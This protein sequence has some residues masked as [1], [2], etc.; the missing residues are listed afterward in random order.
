MSFVMASSWASTQN[1]LFEDEEWRLTQVVSDAR[2]VEAYALSRLRFIEVKK[3]SSPISLFVGDYGEG[4]KGIK[5]QLSGLESHFKYA[6]AR[7]GVPFHFFE[8][9]KIYTVPQEPNL[10]QTESLVQGTWPLFWQACTEAEILPSGLRKYLECLFSA[11]QWGCG[12]MPSNT[13]RKHKSF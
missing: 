13:L 6:L 11:Q 10:M 8:H 7:K 2:I 9:L 4:R 12:A 3:T 5:L 1:L